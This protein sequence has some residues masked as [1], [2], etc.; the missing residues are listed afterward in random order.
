MSI[1]FKDKTFCASPGC[2]NK[3][4][5]KM[6]GAEVVELNKANAPNK[7]NGELLVSYAYFCGEPKDEPKTA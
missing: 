3:C 5:R 7:W 2:M 6:T 1:S 4:G